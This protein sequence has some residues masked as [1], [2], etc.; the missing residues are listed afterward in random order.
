[1]VKTTS[2]K[3]SVKI[4]AAKPLGKSPPRDRHYGL[5]PEFHFYT[6]E[7]DDENAEVEGEKSL[8]STPQAF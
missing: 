3:I 1:M 7:D 6:L 2:K 4:S 5:D 8:F